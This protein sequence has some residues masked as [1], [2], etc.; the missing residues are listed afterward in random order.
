[1]RNDDYDYKADR[2][3]LEAM[4]DARMRQT[5]ENLPNPAMTDFNAGREARKIVI[6]EADVCNHD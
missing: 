5:L 4:L 1:M 6:G 2:E 3:R